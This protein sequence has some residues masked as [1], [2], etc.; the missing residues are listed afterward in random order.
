MDVIVFPMRNAIHGG[1]SN[2]NCDV[3]IDP[4]PAGQKS[5]ARLK[6]SVTT[7]NTDATSIVRFEVWGLS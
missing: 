1:L 4:L 7:L 3:L 6:C 2:E 5:I